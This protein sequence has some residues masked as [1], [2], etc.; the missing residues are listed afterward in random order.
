VIGINEG[1]LAHSH[2]LRSKIQR[3]TTFSFVFCSL[4]RNFDFVEVTFARK[5]KEKQ[6]FPLYFTHFFVTLQRKLTLLTKKLT[7]RMRSVRLVSAL[8]AMMVAGIVC[9]Q[10]KSWPWDFPQGVKIDAE[11]GQKVLSCE[12]FYFDDLK[13]GDDLT[14]S[15]LIWYTREMEQ[16]GAEKS[17]IGRSDKQLV[18]NAMIVP[19]KKGQKAK[20]GDI[21]LTWWQSGSGMQRAIVIDAST[22]TEPVAVYLDRYWKDDPDHK[23]NQELAKGEKL[24]PNSFNVLKDG[25]WQAGAAV[26]YRDGGEWKKGTLMHVDGNKVLLSV[27]SSH[28]FATTKDRCKLIPFK[29]KIKKGDKVW[30]TFVDGFR[31]GYTV[32]E[33]NEKVGRVWV[34]RNGS[35]SM[36]CKSIVEVTKVLD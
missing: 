3:K 25:E 32:K 12:S 5:Y 29:E 4:I 6:H 11:P 26:A 1:V 33:I 34:Q 13:K 14:K 10:D 22:A 19:I 31:D 9:A 30:A 18:P 35:S 8:F 16:V 15:V 2:F 7:K 24:K 20:K 27:F 21:L 28:L 17:D 36:D 23:D